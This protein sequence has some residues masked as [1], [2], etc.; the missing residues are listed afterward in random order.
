M[1]PSKKK[2]KGKK[3]KAASAT[4]EKSIKNDEE[5]AFLEEAMRL[6]AAEEKE[7]KAAAPESKTTADTTSAEKKG[8]RKKKIV[9]TTP[10]EWAEYRK[11]MKAFDK[12]LTDAAAGNNSYTMTSTENFTGMISNGDVYRRSEGL[13]ST[14]SMVQ[15]LKNPMFRKLCDAKNFDVSSGNHQDP[16]E[17]SLERQLKELQLNDRGGSF[18]VTAEEQCEKKCMHGWTPWLLDK[19]TKKKCKQLCN[20]LLNAAVEAS[21]ADVGDFIDKFAYGMQ[22]SQMKTLEVWGDR[23]K[24]EHI[25]RYFLSV[26]AQEL[27]DGKDGEDVAVCAYFARFFEQY[28][29]CFEEGTPMMAAKTYELLFLDHRTIVSFFKNRIECKCLDT[30]YD[31]VKDMPKMAI[32]SNAHCKLPKRRVERSKVLTCSKC[33]QRDYCSRKCQKADWDSHKKTCGKSKELIEEE[34]QKYRE[35]NKELEGKSHHIVQVCL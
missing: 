25:K 10:S 5:D 2:S 34:M 19:E 31:K 22:A 16:H 33:F 18:A 3:A 8:D 20:H 28:I 32:C 29:Q 4:A 11:A 12:D 26:G 30:E 35:Q 1:A 7:I 23:E 17:M 21:E 6:A 14:A 27:C 9:L 13:P 24:L 15:L